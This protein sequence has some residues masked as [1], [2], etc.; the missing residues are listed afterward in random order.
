MNFFFFFFQHCSA[1]APLSG[2]TCV[3][4]PESMDHNSF[5]KTANR[6]AASECVGT[7][8]D[9]GTS[10]VRVHSQSDLL[11]ADPLH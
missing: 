8:V 10:L 7:G 3:R 9:P 11:A 5:G 1:L 6:L 4:L 2:P